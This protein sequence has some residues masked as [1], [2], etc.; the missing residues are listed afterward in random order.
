[1]TCFL[2]PGAGPVLYLTRVTTGVLPLQPSSAPYIHFCNAS[3]AGLGVHEGALCGC[4]CTYV[5]VT[6]VIHHNLPADPWLK[7]RTSAVRP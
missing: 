3:R 6:P 7:T 2:T 5:A 4:L 1:M